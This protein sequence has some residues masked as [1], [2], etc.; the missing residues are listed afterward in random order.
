MV[1]PQFSICFFL[2]DRTGMLH[3]CGVIKCVRSE[4]IINDFCPDL[5]YPFVPF[6]VIILIF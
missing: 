3:Q 2:L 1:L 5:S 4:L 6:L